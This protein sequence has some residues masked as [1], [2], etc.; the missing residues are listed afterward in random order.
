MIK[1]EHKQTKLVKIKSNDR[2]YYRTSVPL[3]IVE[4]VLDAKAGDVLEWTYKRGT[5]IITKQGD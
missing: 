3:W 4:R 5:V 2:I 1:R